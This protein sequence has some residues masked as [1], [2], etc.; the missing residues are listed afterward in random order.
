MKISS[1]LITILIIGCTNS[2]QSVITQPRDFTV[3]ERNQIQ[4]ILV[5]VL[6]SVSN[7]KTELPQSFYPEIKEAN[8]EYFRESLIK[9]EY[10]TT[11]DSVFQ[12][13][14]QEVKNNFESGNY[15]FK[16]YGLGTILKLEDGSQWNPKEVYANILLEKYGVILETIAGDMVN[17][18][19][20][21]YSKTYNEV[22]KNVM[23]HYYQTNISEEAWDLIPV[24]IEKEGKHHP[25]W[26]VKP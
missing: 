3:S 19:L 4:K 2:K 15:I 10:P 16:T 9:S 17:S 5:T 8:P 23:N 20:E 21:L 25:E 12:L 13:A 24:Y 26:K 1:L 11:P 14:L 6:D 7:Q 22:S 18:Q